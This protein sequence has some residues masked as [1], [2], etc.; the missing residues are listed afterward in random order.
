MG[1]YDN[2]SIERALFVIELVA[3]APSALSL[4]EISEALEMSHAT[5]F[6]HLKTLEKNG[7][8]LSTRD[9]K[10]LPGFMLF[11]L[12][13]RHV[14]WQ[15]MAL[16]AEPLV[17]RLAYETEVTAHLGALD[18]NQVVYLRKTDRGSG[19]DIFTKLGMRLDA[20]ATA[21]GK[22][23]LAYLSEADV[24]SLYCYHRLERHTQNTIDNVDTLIGSLK[25]VR[26]RGY[27]VERGESI[28]GIVC[29]AAPIVNTLGSSSLAVSLSAPSSR[30]SDKEIKQL[31]P[32]LRRRVDAFVADV[33]DRPFS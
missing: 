13:R 22:A 2:R 32:Y 33:V 17:R 19:I 10:Y 6:R 28:P 30:F 25:I 21:L 27:A 14:Q 12:G 29:V 9:K 8:L 24:R 20:H 15:T 1:S 5:V 3:S 7:Y 26:A 18:G 4:T 11:R 23:I 16:L 31:G